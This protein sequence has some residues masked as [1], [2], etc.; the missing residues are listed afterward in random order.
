M[1]DVEIR[2]LTDDDAYGWHQALNAGFLIDPGPAREDVEARVPLIDLDRTQGAWDGGRCVGT[3]R[4]FAQ[5]LTVPGGAAVAATAISNVTVTATHRRR[6]LLTAMM[7]ADLAAAKE[8]G[9]AVATLI[10]A[11]YP[12]YGRHGFGPAAWTTAWEVDIPRTGLDRRYAG[13]DDGGTVRLS[14]GA[15]VRALGPELFERFRRGQAGAVTR[16]ERWWERTTGEI[17]VSLGGPWKE[18]YYV[19]YRS[20]QGEV[21][22]LA[23][24]RVDGSDWRSKLPHC[25]ASVDKL[26]AT[27]PAAERAL[28][29]YLCSIDWVTTLKTGFRAPDDVLPL[30]LPDP[31]AA[32]IDSHADFLW[33]R[34]LDTARLLEARTYATAG[35]LVLEVVDAGGLAGGRFLL[36]TDGV[37]STCTATTR[38]AE[39]T[40]PVGELGTLYLGDESPVRLAALGR[41]TEERPGAAARADAL[42]RTARRPWCPDVF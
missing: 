23:T 16:E 28:W 3:F 20:P 11:E 22:G 8:R 31:R 17:R 39:L 41:A 15:E 19:L 38:A 18:P 42:L 27:T 12:I 9:E 34:P 1:N 29:R 35:S 40:L 37:K 6:G 36:E 2:T 5:E 32:R 25:E 13:P 7:A 33:I 4:S 14:D 26:I 21:Q 10:A 24:Y 30:L